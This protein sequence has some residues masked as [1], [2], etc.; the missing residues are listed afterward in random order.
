MHHRHLRL[1]SHGLF[2]LT[3]AVLPLA[4]C[5]TP[6][7]GGSSA[8]GDNKLQAADLR[9]PGR[10]TADGALVEARSHFRNSDYGYS[11]ALYKRVVE[12]S[13]KD[14]EGYIGLGASYDRLGRF[15]LSDRAYA[16]FYQLAGGTAQYYNNIG[17][18][19][20][21]RGNLTAALASFR[22]AMKLD[23]DN[24]V[25]ANNIQI[26]ASAARARA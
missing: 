7:L 4:G 17:Y 2:A 9:N 21:L 8:F 1:F 5:T 15:D 19:Y 24:A 16:S 13:P 22:K 10:Y 23:P 6:F 18:S 11:A 14:P 26:I 3:V 12:L 20:M 25:V